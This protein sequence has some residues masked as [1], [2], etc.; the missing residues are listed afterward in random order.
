MFFFVYRNFHPLHFD[1]NPDEIHQI[2]IDLIINLFCARKSVNKHFNFIM[3]FDSKV[4]RNCFISWFWLGVNIVMLRFML[5]T[6]GIL[7][8]VPQWL[9]GVSGYISISGWCRIRLNQRN[10][11]N[12][13]TIELILSGMF[14]YNSASTRLSGKERTCRKGTCVYHLTVKVLDLAWIK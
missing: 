10:C 2:Q 8:A 3:H 14:A 11:I 7:L 13:K 12:Y 1:R 6:A 4:I 9:H 5:G